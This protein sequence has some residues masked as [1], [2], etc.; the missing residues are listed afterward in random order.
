MMDS[1]LTTFINVVKLKSFTRAA[2]LLNLTQ[3]AV[4][5]H[6]K[7]LEEYY[8]VKLIMKKGRQISLT[9]E[10]ELLFR[11]ARE[12]E[13][14]SHLL[15]RKLKNKSAVI[16][17]YN[18][19]A[20]LTIGEFVLPR[21]LGEYKR[22]HNN[23]DVIMHV[24]NSEEIL[25]KLGNGEFDLGI[26][27]GPFDKDKFNYKKLK[28]DELVLVTAPLNSFVKRAKVEMSEIINNGKLILREKGS[29]TRMIFEKKLL[30]LGYSLSDLKIYMEV[31]SIGA[32]KSLVEANLGYTVVS[33]EAVKREVSIGS[34]V[35]IPI[36]DVRITREFNFIY[37][38]HSPKD[39]TEDF[40]RFLTLK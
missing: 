19:G 14:N 27:E 24:Y 36:E 10:G 9:E 13:S 3:P 28:D 32:I 11:Y 8:K 39:F 38:D 34:L 35:I 17:R 25:K 15:E 2:E 7:Q 16:K 26:V 4:T 20:T 5:Q 40:M 21:L 33:K 37:L 18:I 30:E 22:L 12:F 29:G 1:R 23:I 6:I 31:G